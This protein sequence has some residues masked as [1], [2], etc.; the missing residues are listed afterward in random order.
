LLIFHSL[1]N[2]YFVQKDLETAIKYLQRSTDED[3]KAGRFDE[4]PYFTIIGA[5]LELKRFCDIPVLL[6]VLLRHN[7]D[8]P[9][10]ELL[11][12]MVENRLY[13][14][15]LFIYKLYPLQPTHPSSNMVLVHV[16]LAHQG[17]RDYALAKTFFQQAL[18]SM[19]AAQPSH[20]HIAMVLYYFAKVDVESANP[21][22]ALELVQESVS[23]YDALDLDADPDVTHHARTLLALLTKKHNKK[24]KKNKMKR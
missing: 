12:S 8:P 10:I 9:L 17:L 22:M 23:R 19:M 3:T 24:T 21:K 2:A 11:P 4:T 6:N 5:L 18:D 16:A 20:P 14:E 13:R 7:V 15:A 1:G